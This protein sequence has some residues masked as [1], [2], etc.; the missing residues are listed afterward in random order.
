MPRVWLLHQSMQLKT[1]IM[2]T[3]IWMQQRDNVRTVKQHCIMG[4]QC[5]SFFYM[6]MASLIQSKISS[7]YSLGS[8]NICNF[9]LQFLQHSVDIKGCFILLYNRPH[10]PVSW[11]VKSANFHQ[12]GNLHTKKCHENLCYLTTLWHISVCLEHLLFSK[13]ILYAACTE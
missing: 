13:I 12:G 5:K 4:F 6:M 9:F 11:V 10:L 1:V 2:F 8:I 3:K 7:F